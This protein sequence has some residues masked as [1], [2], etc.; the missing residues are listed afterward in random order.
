MSPQTTSRDCLCTAVTKAGKR[1]SRKRSGGDCNVPYCTQHLKS[2]SKGVP[3][4]K[5]PSIKSARTKTLSIK[6]AKQTDDEVIERLLDAAK[7]LEQRVSELENEV[8]HR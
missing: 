7:R 4:T 1:C 6:S 8:S 3:R 2:K 5:T